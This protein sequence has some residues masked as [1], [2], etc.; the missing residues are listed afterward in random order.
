L[1][2][3]A[4]ELLS[5]NKDN[6]AGKFILKTGGKVTLFAKL[7]TKGIQI[8]DNN[9][10]VENLMGIVGQKVKKNRQSRVD[11]NLNIMLNTIWYIIS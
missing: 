4:N 11:A 6:N 9:N 10:H 8:P 2:L 3:I 5:K 1:L 7:A